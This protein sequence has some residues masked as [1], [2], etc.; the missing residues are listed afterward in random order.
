MHQ[1][2]VGEDDGI[3]EACGTRRR[4]PFADG[5]DFWI[6]GKHKVKYFASLIATEPRRLAAATLHSWYERASGSARRT[7]RAASRSGNLR[8]AGF[9]LEVHDVQHCVSVPLIDG[10][11]KPIQDLD[12]CAWPGR[13]VRRR[14]RR[15]RRECGRLHGGLARALVAIIA[16]RHQ[17]QRTASQQ[18][19]DNR[20]E[21]L[22]PADST[23]TKE[24]PAPNHLFLTYELSTPKTPQ[25]IMFIITAMKRPR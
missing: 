13:V 19:Q 12:T 17:C 11:E 23:Q 18:E 22:M 10:C 21:R 8:L 4:S 25:G 9:A 5:E 6:C 7:F 2:G 16:S 15:A 20:N 24:S 14:R 3:G 1:R